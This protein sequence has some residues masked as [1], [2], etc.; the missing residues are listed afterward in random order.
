MN[1]TGKKKKEEDIC[2]V[3]EGTG[4]FVLPNK[5][6]IDSVEIKEKI[7]IGLIEKGYSFRQVQ[8][9]LGYKSVRSISYIMK[10]QKKEKQ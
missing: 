4:R 10:K 8:V 7:V 9:A 5:I 1:D 2:P 3:C 6:D